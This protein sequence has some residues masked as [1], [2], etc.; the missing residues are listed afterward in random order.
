MVSIPPHTHKFDLI[1]ATAADV[2]AGTDSTKIV[3][4]SAISAI[5]PPDY[6]TFALAAAASINAV[7]Q[8]VRTNGRDAIGDGGGADF[9][10]AASQPSHHLKFIDALGQWWE[11]SNLWISPRMYGAKP[12]GS[13][14][15]DA[16]LQ[17]VADPFTKIDWGYGEYVTTDTLIE[18]KPNVT[19]RGNATL[20]MDLTAQTAKNLVRST[21]SATGFKILSGMTFDHNAEG[22]PSPLFVQQLAVSITDCI[23]IMGNDSEVDC[24]VNNAYGNGVSFGDFTFSGDG[25]VAHPYDATTTPYYPVRCRFGRIYGTNNGCG[26]AAG[27]QFGEVGKK[28]SVV[29]ILSASGVCGNYVGGSHNYGGFIVDYASGAD[30]TV[31]M[32]S[33]TN[34]L[35]DAT[36]PFNGSGIAVSIQGQCS[37]G[38]LHSSNAQRAGVAVPFEF[39][40]LHVGTAFIWASQQQGVLVSAGKISGQFNI[41]NC[42]LGNVG[43]LNAFDVNAS[44]DVQLQV[45]IN[46]YGNTHAF[47]YYGNPNGHVI[48]GKV[49]LID[50]NGVLDRFST[51][52]KEF[53]TASMKSG[54]P[55][56]QLAGAV[57]IGGGAMV[58]STTSYLQVQD[59]ITLK[60]GFAQPAYCYN[61][62]WDFSNWRY[63]GNGAGAYLKMQSDGTIVRG[64]APLA[65]PVR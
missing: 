27:G 43:V 30:C 37:I 6:D 36:H 59:S 31:G 33:F 49:N 2:L 53:V 51:T 7:V 22:I 18:S 61:L 26:D 64:R 10:R 56:Q 20:R 25:S 47:G 57:L 38:T 48:S 29:N 13:N 24:V 23:L 28:G 62:V 14:S 39:S 34:T 3:T 40:D 1:E 52:G 9:K 12:D 21:Q 19:W 50:N 8:A 16:L 60:K 17:M 44:G 63:V 55:G 4:P 5:R 42:S 41:G 45:D 32:V 15:T 11:V 54:L 65:S 35:I 58:Q 46:V